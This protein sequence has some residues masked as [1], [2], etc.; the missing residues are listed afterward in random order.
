MK[1]KLA[2]LASAVTLAATPILADTSHD[3]P[4]TMEEFM[5]AYP[6][7]TP[8]E[9]AL[10]DSDGDGEIS[11]EEYLSGQEMGLISGSNDHDY[12]ELDA[13]GPAD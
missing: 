1:M 10:I 6:D 2:A 8:E 11:E 13:E 12:D 5:S 3:F 9:F 4:L 7:V